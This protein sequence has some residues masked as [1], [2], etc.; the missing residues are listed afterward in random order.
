MTDAGDCTLERLAVGERARVTSLALE[1]DLAGWVEAVGLYVGAELEV[2]RRAPLGG[3]LHVRGS[4]GAEFA[5]ARS[6]ATS[7]RVRKSAP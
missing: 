7:I 4:D 2:L 3:P 5:L 6:L 1:G